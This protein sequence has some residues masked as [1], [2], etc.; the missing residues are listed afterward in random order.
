MEAV[1]KK[2][3]FFVQI[4]MFYFYNKFT[5]LKAV[6]GFRGSVISFYIEYDN[7]F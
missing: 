4:S 2:T 3:A 5:N 1:D 7:Y 6:L